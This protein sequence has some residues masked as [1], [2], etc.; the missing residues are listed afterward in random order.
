MCFYT[1]RV[2][3]CGYWRWD[4]FREQCKDET[5]MGETCGLKLVYETVK[6]S[7]PCGICDDIVKKQRKI[8]KM[9]GDLDRWVR[10]GNKPYTIEKALVER[11][12]A[13]DKIKTLQSRH[14]RDMNTLSVSWGGRKERKEA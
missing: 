12:E 6:I 2:W 3:S 14:S 13:V 11:K 8:V 9:D 4:K 7:A 10:E 5:R 1:Q